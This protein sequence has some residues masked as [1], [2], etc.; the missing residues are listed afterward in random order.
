LVATPVLAHVPPVDAPA[1][2]PGPAAAPPPRVEL[3]AITHNDELLEQIGQALDGESAIRLVDSIDEAGEH[4]V[5]SRP[6]VV[7]VDAREYEDLGSS[8]D[9]VQ[10][11]SDSCVV[12][13]FAPASQASEMASA[14]KRSAA[15]AVLPIPVE[16]GKTTAVLEGARAEAMS[17]LIITAPLKPPPRAAPPVAPEPSPAAPWTAPNVVAGRARR[18]PSQLLLLGA[19]GLVLLMIA[20]AWFVLRGFPP[21]AQQAGRKQEPTAA[22]PPAAAPVAIAERAPDRVETG[23]IEALLDKAEIAF[24]ERRY[25][26]PAADSA[27]L[28]YRSVQAQAPD[29]GEA[30]EGLERVRSVLDSRLQSALAERRFDDAAAAMAQLALI[31]PADARLAPL[32]ARIADTQIAAAFENGKIERAS[33]LLRQATLARTLPSDRSTYWRDE[34]NRRQGAARVQ[35]AADAERRLAEARAPGVSTAAVAP[36]ATG[37]AP[38]LAAPPPLPESERLTRLVQQRISEGRLLTPGQDSA[39]FHYNALRAADPSGTSAPAQARA[40]SAALIEHA[41]GALSA[42]T[43]D[44][45]QAH[46]AAARQL[47]LDLATLDALERNLAAAR[48]PPTPAPRPARTAALERTYYVPPAYPQQALANDVRGEVRVRITVDTEGR[49]KNAEVL[50][51]APAGVFEQAA[52]AAVRRWR[53]RPA[54]A[55]GQAI[56]A[57][58]VTALVFRPADGARR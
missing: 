6:Q 5:A 29:N 22:S 57:T 26:E 47:G 19:A 18:R 50:A 23:S 1:R 10:A 2:A 38:A 4:I 14:I 21:T 36:A 45:A 8:V 44:V 13:V 58:T 37:Q 48:L 52:L 35:Q 3:I 33:Q 56:E 55:D 51:S 11:W 40:L 7:M 24:R 31:Q 16:A 9:R 54:E 34:I 43:L 27:L 17:R 30:R 12:V 46:L 25:T 20:V 32:A 53:F 49:V 42:G 15:F 41:S 39:L 28:Y